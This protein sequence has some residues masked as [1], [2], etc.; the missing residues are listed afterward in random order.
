MNIATVLAI[1]VVK[2]Q[3]MIQPLMKRIAKDIKK[4]NKVRFNYYIINKN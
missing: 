1:Q 4:E 2:A 3:M